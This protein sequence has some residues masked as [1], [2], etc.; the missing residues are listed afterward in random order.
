MQTSAN[1]CLLIA[2]VATPLMGGGCA[3]T[4]ACAIEDYDTP[5]TVTPK[6]R[7]EVLNSLDAPVPGV[8]VRIEYYKVYCDGRESDHVIKEGATGAEGIFST[9][10]MVEHRSFV[11]ANPN[12]DIRAKFNV[13]KED[14]SE[15]F[16]DVWPGEA[17]DRT[18]DLLFHWRCVDGVSSS[19]RAVVE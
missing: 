15:S 1:I 12:D 4:V 11:I 6:F 16:E 7:L 17:I 13:S 3:D 8:A 2:C 9:E 14:W 19:C 18:R 5:R 10:L